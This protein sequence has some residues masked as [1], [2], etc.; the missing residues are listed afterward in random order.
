MPTAVEKD[1]GVKWSQ[2]QIPSADQ[3]TSSPGAASEKSGATFSH[4]PAG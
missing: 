4:S 1:T 2:V 3:G